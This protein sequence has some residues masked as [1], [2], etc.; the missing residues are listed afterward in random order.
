MVASNDQQP[1][2]HQ[3]VM[4][5]E[6]VALLADVPAG[7]VLDATVGG[8]GHALAL[9]ERRS[10]ISVIGLDRDPNALA[11]AGERLDSHRHRVRL[12]RARFDSLADVVASLDVSGL[13]GFLF[14]FGVSSPQLDQ[15]ERGF[16]FRHDGPLDM[17]MDTDASTSASD[18]VNGYD[19][20]TLAR[21]L[22]SHGDE[23]F[24][25]RI[26]R[27]IIEARPIDRTARLAEI[28]VSAIPA[29][30]RRT[31]GH[32][33]KRT[34]QAIRIEVNDELAVIE[35]ALESALD[36]LVVGGRGIVLTYHSGEDRIAKDVFRRRTEST[37]PPGLP[38]PVSEPSFSAIRPLAKRPTDAEVER[39]RRAASARMRAVER[40]AA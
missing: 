21:I 11:A 29:A 26:A 2:A 16:S 19:Q 7:E 33:A 30:A 3:P 25:T 28:V 22:R 35:P 20:A 40:L 37:D 4:V 39:N 8:G 9:L 36:L 1:F 27:A 10:D 34:F 12:E 15:A 38:V 14:D 32:P 5:D 24:A 6:V 17:R 23:R 18:I 13:S 31:G